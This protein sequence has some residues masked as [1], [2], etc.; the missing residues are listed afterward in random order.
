VPTQ[1]TLGETIGLTL[2]KKSNKK[3]Q[4]YELNDFVV[5]SLL[6]Y[7]TFGSVLL[8]KHSLNESPYALKMIKKDGVNI[9]SA[10]KQN[11]HISNEIEVLTHIS[12]FENSFYPKLYDTMKNDNGVFLILDY[13]PGGELFTYLRT[14]LTIEESGIKF[15]MAEVVVALE[16]LHS[17]NIIYRDLKPENLIINKDGHIK[18]VDFGFS[19][20]LKEGEFTYTG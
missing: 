3:V 9:Y 19:K 15:Y 7:G 16:Q 12:E 6:G 4:R 2:A 8:V 10:K 11:E 13:I 17:E 14:K 5:L 20:F 18:L 1:D